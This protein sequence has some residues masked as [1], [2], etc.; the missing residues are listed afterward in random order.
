MSFAQRARRAPGT[1]VRSRRPGR[2]PLPLRF[3]AGAVLV[4][5]GV[6]SVGVV[7]ATTANAALAGNWITRDEIMTRAQN[8]V[9]Q[10]KSLEYDDSRKPETFVP[11]PDGSHRYAPDCS[12]F[13]SMAWHIDPG[14]TG[15]LTSA[16]LPIISQ[17]IDLTELR[18]GDLLNRSGYH[19]LLFAG[20]AADGLHF[21]Y[22]SF[23]RDGVDVVQGASFADVELS[24]HPTTTY[25]AFR[26]VNVIEDSAPG[27]GAE[28]IL[29][30]GEGEEGAYVM[31]KKGDLVVFPNIAGLNAQWGFGRVIGQGWGTP[32]RMRFLDLTGDGRDELFAFGEDTAR[33]YL[34]IDGINAQWGPLIDVDMGLPSP[35]LVFVAD[36]DG[37]GAD[38]VVYLDDS[39]L[40][41]ITL[42]FVNGS[43]VDSG[44]I[45]RG[46]P[47]RRRIRFAD[48][49][50]DGKDDLV[51]IDENGD[52]RVFPNLDGAHG[53]WGTAR[54]VGTGWC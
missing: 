28:G 12:G 32:E 33:A 37:N 4:V 45:S 25:R 36:L 39:D 54:V 3:L 40:R 44:V 20:W 16:Q 7:A 5:S 26:Y 42:D 38:D 46:W 27:S 35:E 6:Q 13:V 8:W 29:P 15:G 47:D 17:Q 43:V 11:D 52:L 48:L 14:E 21:A 51:S 18:R 10:G 23:S 41:G 24:G 49:D 19:S 9:D 50:G 30:G 34:N 2:S 22:L 31:G 1:A 53:S